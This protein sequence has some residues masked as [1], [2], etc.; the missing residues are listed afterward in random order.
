MNQN[1]IQPINVSINTKVKTCKTYGMMH[2]FITL[3][4]LCQNFITLFDGGELRSNHARRISLHHRSI[5]DEASFNIDLSLV[6]SLVVF[7]K[8]GNDILNFGKYQLLRVLDLEDCTDFQNDHLREVCNL[9]LLK[10]LSL[11]GNVTSLPKEIKQLKL[12]E[13]LDL[14]RTNV[15]ILPTEVIQLPYLIHLLGKFQL[16]DKAMQDE[17]QKFLASGKCKLQT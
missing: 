5:T 4:S 15:K 11:G 7:G 3:K 17:L 13:T 1:I 14:R 2:E 10:Y 12:L 9:L 6:R 16:E 8:A